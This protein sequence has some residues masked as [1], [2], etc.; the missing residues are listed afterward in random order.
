MNFSTQETPST[1]RDLFLRIRSLREEA[2]SKNPNPVR[3]ETLSTVLETAFSTVTP[4]NVIE[5]SQLQ[6]FMERVYEE[7]DK[8]DNPIARL[9]LM[10]VADIAERMSRENMRL[11]IQVPKP[12]VLTTLVPAN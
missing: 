5:P 11:S 4:E 6:A 8:T 1:W 3:S 2:T 7:R 9:T 12:V 10:E